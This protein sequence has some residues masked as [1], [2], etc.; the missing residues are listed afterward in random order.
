[1]SIIISSYIYVFNK[2]ASFRYKFLVQSEFAAETVILRD[3]HLFISGM[4]ISGDSRT[5]W[6][7]FGEYVVVC[8]TDG[9]RIGDFPVGDIQDITADDEGNIMVLNRSSCV[10]VFADITTNDSD[11]ETKHDLSVN[12]VNKFEVAPEARAIA[13]HWTTGNVI[14]V[15][16]TSDGRSKV[17]LYSKE[18][19]LERRIDIELEKEDFIQVA[20]VT[21]DGSIY[22][23]TSK[24]V[25]VL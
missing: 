16:E 20:T 13:F 23:K 8:K 6:D 1:M 5:L 24:K 14:I 25:L 2:E 10:S 9:K 17:L 19:K 3:N 18:G 7:E 12:F 15:S 4:F 21:T 11:D 22:V